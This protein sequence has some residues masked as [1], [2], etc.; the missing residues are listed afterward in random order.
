MSFDD[1]SFDAV[2]ASA[3]L[4]FARDTRH[5]KAMLTELWR[6]LTPGGFFFARL[7][8]TIGIEDRV[9]PLRD[10]RFHLPDGSDRFLVDEALL[11]DYASALGAEQVEPIK[12]TNVQNLRAMTTWCLVKGG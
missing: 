12:T 2:L 7:A 6:V 8:S 3:V 5:F 10:R 1:G 4:H 11:T 9:E